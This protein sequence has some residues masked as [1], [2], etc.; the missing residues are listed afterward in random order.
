MGLYCCAFTKGFYCRTFHE[1][2]VLCAFTEGYILALFTEEW[3]CCWFH[4]RAIRLRFSRKGY[5]TVAVFTKGRHVALS[6]KTN[7][8]AIF[9]RRIQHFD[10]HPFFIRPTL[11]HILHLPDV[12]AYLALAHTCLPA[13]L[14]F[15]PHL[16]IYFKIISLL[17]SECSWSCLKCCCCRKWKQ[18]TASKPVQES[19]SDV[20]YIHYI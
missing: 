4:K 14:M 15:L 17:E 7:M 8:V 6:W 20:E 12:W 1:R 18:M 10:A 13:I 16:F 5:Y 9:H 3:Y 11:L 19:I 2:A